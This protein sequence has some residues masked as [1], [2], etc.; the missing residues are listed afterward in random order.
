MRASCSPPTPG[1]GCAWSCPALV[2]PAGPVQGGT[3]GLEP[4]SDPA[5]ALADLR[6][7]R[8]VRYAG[9]ELWDWEDRVLASALLIGPRHDE[10]ALARRPGALLRAGLVRALRADGPPPRLAIAP[11]ARLANV[12][13]A[14]VGVPGEGGPD[15]LRLVERCTMAIAPPAGL[16]A[17]LSERPRR[18][19][20][21]A[22]AFA[23]VDPGADLGEP[24]PDGE[25]T[26]ARE[27][28]EHL[29]DDVTVLTPSTDVS[30]AQIRRPRSATWAF[31]VVLPAALAEPLTCRDGPPKGPSGGGPCTRVVRC[32]PL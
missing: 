22:L 21:P 2:P 12:P 18:T 10:A 25:L 6:D 3:L 19:E 31:V 8:P 5:S 32:S 20:T 15:D 26:G 4:G 29:P 9:E 23:L 11:A 13:W 30:S 27:L 1:P 16:L 7:V 24:D 28:L 14:A 17:S